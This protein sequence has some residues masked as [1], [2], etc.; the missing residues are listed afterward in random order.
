[1]E[2]NIVVFLCHISG[3]APHEAGHSWTESSSHYSIEE[4]SLKSLGTLALAF[5]C[6]AGS[7][8]QTSGVSM[9]HQNGGGALMVEAVSRA[10]SS[11]ADRAESHGRRAAF[12][13]VISSN[14]SY[15][16]TLSFSRLTVRTGS[17]AS[18]AETSDFLSSALREAAELFERWG[19]PVW[20]GFEAG[21]GLMSAA[22]GAGSAASGD[23]GK[24][25][26]W[27]TDLAFMRSLVE[28]QMVDRSA[29]PCATSRATI[30]L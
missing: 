21:S 10:I 6:G 13:H 11:Q 15:S 14:W 12:C 28:R 27:S 29:L 17:C 19:L 22:V 26:L 24:E 9:E 20:S 30:R 3:V 25:E 2:E 16:K 18:A 5:N 23:A 1:M 4:P 7:H 8:M